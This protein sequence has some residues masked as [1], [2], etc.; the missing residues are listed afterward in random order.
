[1]SVPDNKSFLKIISGADGDADEVVENLKISEQAKLAFDGTDM[2]RWQ[3]SCR[4]LDQ[5]GYGAAVVNAYKQN[6]PLLANLVDVDRAITLADVMS[7]IAI[8]AGRRAAEVMPATAIK[9]AQRLDGDEARFRSWTSLMERFADLAPESVE[10]VLFKMDVLL[11]RLNVTQLEAWILA[12]VRAAGSDS[13]SRLNFFTFEDAEA[14]RWLDHESGSVVF[15]DIDREL[16]AYLR[17]LWK[18][19]VPMREPPANAPEQTRRRSSFSQGVIRIPSSF[20]GY[21]GDQA[22]DLYRAGLAHIGAHMMFSGDRFP[23]KELR[24]LQVVLVSLIEDARVEQLAIR[25]F[26]GLRRLWLQFHVAQ[27]TESMNAP[28][29]MAR[30]SRTL[31]DPEFHDVNGWIQRA[32]SMFYDRH[33]KWENPAISREIGNLIGNDLGQMRVQFNAKTYVVE[34]PYRDDN[35]GLWD[36]GDEDSP[37]FAEAEQLFDSIRIEQQEENDDAP[38]DQEREEQEE[39]DDE[40]ANRVNMELLEQ[41]GVPVARYP[42]YDYVT[43]SNRPDWTTLVEFAPPPG[44]AR[45]IDEILENQAYVVNRIKSLIKSARVSRPERLNRQQEGEYLDL[46]ACIEAV[47]SR[48][49]GETPDPHVYSRAECRHRDLSVLVLLD[50]SE[51]T[52]DKVVGSNNSVLELERQA[53]ALLAHAMSGLG[54]PFALAAFC[55]NQRDE[56][57]YYR[58]KDFDSPYQDMSKANLAGLKSGF[59][60][61]IG[62]AMRHA[63]EDLKHQQTHRKLLLVVTDGEPSDIDVPDRRYLVEDA[64]HVVHDLAHDGIDVFCVG[65]DSG[66]D[67]YLTRIFGRRNVVQIDRL[68]RLPERLPM[69]YFRLTA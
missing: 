9:A 50:I 38:P 27:A 49:I 39:S 8:K 66:G 54:D 25:E 62:T 13:E 41:D 1:M 44:N 7:S 43:S 21:R 60:T 17:A 69:I 57:R 35:M 55:S 32:R 64:R 61:R 40:D 46:N 67:S 28:S 20:P 33:D 59:S 2:A 30:L 65:L 10:P 24:P 63:A 37:E 11:S 52:K 42:E 23:V 19:R 56:V 34:P 53:T 3:R 29:L 68:E 45:D 4:K 18:V 6:S 51:S 36:F 47:I 15:T 48:R 58:V 22:A 16:K 31:L 12:G 26:P 5:A 14:S